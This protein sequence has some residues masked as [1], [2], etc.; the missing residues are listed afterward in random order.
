MNNY[1]TWPLTRRQYRLFKYY[2]ELGLSL[3]DADRTIHTAWIYGY[4]DQQLP[5]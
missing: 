1:Y 5:L 2:L 4:I 3:E